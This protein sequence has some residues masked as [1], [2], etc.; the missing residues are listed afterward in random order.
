MDIEFSVKLHIAHLAIC[1]LGVPE[2]ITK[3]RLKCHTKDGM[4]STLTAHLCRF[5][6][7]GQGKSIQVL[8][9]GCRFRKVE[10]TLCPARISL[11]KSENGFFE[12]L[13]DKMEQHNHPTEVISILAE[14]SISEM[15]KRSVENPQ[16]K[17]PEIR[18]WV[19]EELFNSHTDSDNFHVILKEE[20]G[21]AENIEKRINRFRKRKTALGLSG[22]VPTESSPERKDP[23]DVEE[24]SGKTRHRKNLRKEHLW[25][26]DENIAADEDIAPDENIVADENVSRDEDIAPYENISPDKNIKSELAFDSL[27][28]VNSKRVAS[29]YNDIYTIL[30]RVKLT[31]LSSKFHKEMIDFDIL[32][33]STA[34][35]LRKV[36]GIPFGLAKQIKVEADKIQEETAIIDYFETCQK[37][38]PGNE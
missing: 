27:R 24:L 29:N 38:V 20:L 1:N 32:K 23:E 3:Y 19:E 15:E 25:N 33:I 28:L 4:P 16:I 36:L 9:Y 13:P 22:K 11:R 18:R 30:S 17:V 5:V 10:L 26:R 12:H 34:L 21:S 7:Q 35:E 31:Q 8:Y 14:K 6:K 37:N 2:E